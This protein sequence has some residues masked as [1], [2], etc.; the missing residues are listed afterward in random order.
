MNQEAIIVAMVGSSTSQRTSDPVEILNSV[1]VAIKG[2]TVGY[3]LFKRQPAHRA[4][5]LTGAPAGA[6]HGTDAPLAPC[7]VRG[8]SPTQ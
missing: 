1:C 3:Y 8:Q 4:S 5:T 7:T 6:S 2:S